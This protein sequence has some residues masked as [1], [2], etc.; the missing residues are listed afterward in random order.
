MSEKS[1][2]V[3]SWLLNKVDN[4]ILLFAKVSFLALVTSF[5]I[6]GLSSFAF[7]VV[8]VMVSCLIRL[9]ERFFNKANH[10]KMFYL[11]FFVLNR[12]S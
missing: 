11:I 5:S 9:I 1:L 7:S 4:T 3:A 2:L 8:V 10:V 6:K 12:V